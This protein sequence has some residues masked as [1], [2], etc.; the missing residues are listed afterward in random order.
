[1]HGLDFKPEPLP[2]DLG[3]GSLDWSS[4]LSEAGLL[5]MRYCNYA[6]DEICVSGNGCDCF[7]RVCEL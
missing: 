4:A 6:F 7:G 2:Q 3:A 5:Q 1:M